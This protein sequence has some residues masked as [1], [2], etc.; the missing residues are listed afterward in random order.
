M[1]RIVVACEPVLTPEAFQCAVRVAAAARP[2]RHE[3]IAVLVACFPNTRDP[4]GRGALNSIYRFRCS[5]PR[6]ALALLTGGRLPVE[7]EIAEAFK[8]AWRFGGPTAA[9][10]LVA[11]VAPLDLDT[12]LDLLGFAL[13]S[14]QSAVVAAVLAVT[15]SFPSVCPM[16]AA[17]LVSSCQTAD[18]VALL[19]DAGR[20][21]AGRSFARLAQPQSAWLDEACRWRGLR[22]AWLGCHA[23]QRASGV[24][25][26]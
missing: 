5:D 2:P 23:G 9:R 8:G 15:P 19:T 12:A 3:S 16:A 18:A 4:L 25:D 13:L 6:F 17:H 14:S 22:R 21:V 1:R 20:F 26:S 10:E 7:S 24:A 11:S